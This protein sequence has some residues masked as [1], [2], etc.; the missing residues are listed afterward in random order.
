[1]KK[2]ITFLLFMLA[3][4]SNINAQI[5]FEEHFDTWDFPPAGWSTVDFDYEHWHTSNSTIAGGTGME[6][7]LDWYPYTDIGMARLISPEIDLTGKTTITLSF[8]QKVLHDY[9]S[10]E[11]G[12]ATRSNGGAWNIAWSTNVT[13]TILP[14][15]R[16]INISN[17]DVNSSTFQFCLYFDGDFYNFGGWYI[18]DTEISEPATTDASVLDILGE[19]QFSVGDAYIPTAN[20]QNVGLNTESVKTSCTIMDFE[21]GIMAYTD[22][23]TVSISAGEVSEVAFP[24]FNIPENSKVYEVIVQTHL[25]GDINSDND[26][27]NRF[28]NTYTLERQMVLVEIGTG[29]WCTNCTSAAIGADDLVNN[30]HDAAIIEHHKSDDYEIPDALT[31][32]DYYGIN[33]Y[34]TAFFDGQTEKGGGCPSLNCYDEYLPIYNNA[35][36]VNSPL[37]ISITGAETSTTG[38]YNIHV[39]LDKSEPVQEENLRLQVALTES[40]IY[41]PW[42]ISPPLDY[43]DYVNRGFFP[44]ANGTSIDLLNNSNISHEFTINAADY[45][46]ENCEIVAFVES[47]DDK[48]IYQTS[49]VKLDD[50]ITSIFSLD[51]DH[52]MVYPN[53]SSD[54]FHISIDQEGDENTAYLIINIYGEIIKRGT[55][56]AGVNSINLSEL[57]NGYYFIRISKGDRTYVKKITLVK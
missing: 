12:V 38:V 32:I 39:N 7:M 56:L 13:E 57:A 51:S 4:L 30:G 41:H 6:V 24:T 22:T 43:L 10:F 50:L 33:G 19:R 53:P 46:I 48:Y 31:R 45:D 1:M 11:V 3:F 29:T 44:D 25:V 20:I 37:T 18:D 2:Q 42:G 49:K 27:L 52:I 15:E 8:K 47:P 26:E 9:D 35:K 16:V 40:H 23:V 55:L 28:I 5:L 34:P 14:E 17:S 36:A 54:L 21:T